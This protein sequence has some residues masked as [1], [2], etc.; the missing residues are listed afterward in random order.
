MRQCE[1]IKSMGRIICQVTLRNPMDADHEIT[2]DGLVDTR[3]SHLVL[4]LDWRERLGKFRSEQQVALSL[5]SDIIEGTL[6]GPVEVELEGFRPVFTEALFVDMQPGD[7]ANTKPSS[8]TSSWKYIPVA[9][10]MVGHRLVDA[11]ALGVEVAFT[12]S[13]PDRV[14][15]RPREYVRLK[16]DVVRVAGPR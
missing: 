13:H 2:F 9:V 10:D 14:G 7:R 1:Q 16:V 12:G 15:A 5:A 11:G 3:A 8:V 6:C 4:P